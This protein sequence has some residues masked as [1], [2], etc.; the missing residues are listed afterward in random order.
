MGS[1]KNSNQKKNTTASKVNDITLIMESGSQPLNEAQLA[2]K[3]KLE[4]EYNQFMK[5][6]SESISKK[7][8]E[9]I[10]QGNLITVYEIDCTPKYVFIY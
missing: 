3:N 5:K 6:F 2:A 9:I 7:N 1:R 8:C 10:E 4:E